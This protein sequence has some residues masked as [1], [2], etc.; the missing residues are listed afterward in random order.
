[1][2]IGEAVRQ[3][4]AILAAGGVGP[5]A[6][7]A[8]QLAA[9]CFGLP[10]S[11]LPLEADA[12]AAP[13]AVERLGK[14]AARRTAGEPLQYLLGEWEFYGLPFAVGEGVLIPRPDTELL[15]DAALERLPANRPARVLELCAGSGCIAAAVAVHRPA[16]RV[17]AL[18]KSPAAFEYLAKN[19]HRLAAGRVRP[20]LGDLLE[21]PDEL[22]DAAP[23]DLLL[24]NPP[25]I[26]AGDLP[27]LSR[28]VQR[29]PAMALDGGPDGLRFYR[30]ICE[31][32]LSCLAP[33]GSLLVEIGAGQSAAVQAIFRQAGLRE[34]AALPDIAG[35]ERVIV[36]TLPDMPY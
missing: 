4:V 5:A 19:T 9:A 7:E 30:A 10:A 33:G 20:V 17:T 34:I 2:T 27:G 6:F 28:E 15:V 32:W 23:F 29:E 16:C 21:G 1:M 24:S 14:L 35:I 26:P 18:E 12:P 22:G 3:T 8:R 11:R 13:E 25:Y 31:N 36:G